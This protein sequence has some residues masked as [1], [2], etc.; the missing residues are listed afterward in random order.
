[1][2]RRSQTEPGGRTKAERRESRT[3]RKHG[4][5]TEQGIE[6]RLRR[7]EDAVAT[8]AKRSE[9]LLSRL[10]GAAGARRAVDGETPEGMEQALRLRRESVV[11][12]DQPLA[13]ISQAQRSGG[14]LLARLFDGHPQCHAHPHELHIGD[15]RPHVWPELALDE[16]P[17]AWF[18]KLKEERL[19]AM[20]G[21]GKRKIP[22]KAQGEKQEESYYP[23]IL[24][25]MFQEE[26]FLQEVE[27]RSPIESEREILDAYMTSLF[28]AWLDN[29][30][31]YGADKRWVVA[32]SPRRA[33]AERLDKHFELYPDGR[34]I[35]IIRD[36]LSWYT[37]AQGRD[38]KAKTE[39]LLEHWKR[40]AREMSEAKSRY[41]KRV[42][43]VRFEGLVSKTAT[44]MR[45]LAGFLGIDYDK[46]LAAPTFNGN[47][48]GANSSFD[49][50]STGVV[51]DPV[52][53]YKEILSA[54][55]QELIS[56][57][58]EALHQEVLALADGKPARKR[59]SR[60]RASQAKKS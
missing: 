58:C 34:L 30:N 20:F 38:P 19:G 47:P 16:K 11:P 44:T 22:L 45:Q 8:Q 42:C 15:K 52:E 9:E 40:S 39:S 4:E 10:T 1:M 14:T 3:G 53:R 50:R 6:S 33:W 37:S 27:R 54:E 36:P 12:V 51:T 26:L 28:N 43:I 7:I 31:L 25:P 41:S 23:F 46:R 49:V 17:A 35:S 13:L 32:F 21:K 55:K 60:P 5:P 18:A 59:P 57:E 56:G 48:V 29:Q 24:P 2:A